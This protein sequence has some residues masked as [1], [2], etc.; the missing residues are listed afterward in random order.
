M[1]GLGNTVWASVRCA[2]P[3]ATFRRKY[4]L[5][6]P[7]KLL[8]RIGQNV[9]V[10]EPVAQTN[11]YSEYHWINVARG[12]GISPSRVEQYLQAQA[13]D[14]IFDGYVL[15]GPIGLM[16]RVFRSPYNGKI[17]RV[18]KGQFLVETEVEPFLLKA[19]VTGTVV[20]LIEDLG[21][22]IEATGD[23]IQG[24]WGN[25]KV[26]KGNLEVLAKSPN[27]ILTPNVLGDHL[28]R[29]I[30]IG[31][32]CEDIETLKKA[33]TFS[34]GGLIL[35]SMNSR[36]VSQALSMDSPIMVME[37]F[38]KHSYNPVTFKF[39]L[40]VD[41]KEVIL[42]AQSR[43]QAFQGDPE[44][45]IISGNSAKTG[46]IPQGALLDVGQRVRVISGTYL[47]RTGILTKL[48]GP[49]IQS[50]GIRVD[51]GEVKL[52]SGES[53]TQPLRNLEIKHLA[54]SH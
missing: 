30:V 5:P 21:V 42:N 34:L 46:L 51:A 13:G 23:L 2:S 27:Q 15:A 9:E 8:V 29:K 54:A 22:V 28:Q 43:D 26:A 7:G 38:G 36:L 49:V 44:L 14:L 18:E 6:A 1:E 17:L 25:G 47:G 35:A 48:L 19:G 3:Q 16:R 50:N 45:V 4:L 11:I 37:G 31:G 53:L 24:V 39:L 12:L 52:D 33:S 10:L 41:R 32:H 20:D 40:T